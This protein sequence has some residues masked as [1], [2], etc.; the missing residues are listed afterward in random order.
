[1]ATYSVLSST[2]T[3]ITTLTPVNAVKASGAFNI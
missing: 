2:T 3:V 1:M